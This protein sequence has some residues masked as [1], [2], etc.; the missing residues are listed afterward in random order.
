MRH[1]HGVRHS[2]TFGAVCH[3]LKDTRLARASLTSLRSVVE[4]DTV[5]RAR[6]RRLE[7]SRGGFILLGIE[8]AP[9]LI[10]ACVARS[11]ALARDA[12]KRSKRAF[13]Q[14]RSA[15]AREGAL[16]PKLKSAERVAGG[17]GGSVRVGPALNATPSVRTSRSVDSRSGESGRWQQSFRGL[18]D[19]FSTRR[20]KARSRS[21]PSIATRAQRPAEREERRASVSH[22][23]DPNNSLRLSATGS[24]QQQHQRPSQS[25]PPHAS[26]R[27][28]FSFESTTA[29]DAGGALDD[30]ERFIVGSMSYGVGTEL[31]FEM[32]SPLPG[33]AGAGTESKRSTSSGKYGSS[34]RANG[35]ALAIPN[36]HTFSGPSSNS[37]VNL[38]TNNVPAS[39][40]MAS[41]ETGRGPS[42]G[43]GSGPSQTTLHVPLTNGRA[44][45]PHVHT[46]HIQ[47]SPQQQHS[48]SIHYVPQ[49]DRTFEPDS[50]VDPLVTETYYGQWK[51]DKRCGFGICVRSDGL[52]YEGEL[53]NNMR[54]GTPV[55]PRPL[56]PPA[57]SP[58]EPRLDRVLKEVSG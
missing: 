30:I 56:P 51:A 53:W 47:Y 32:D 1:G 34:G 41:I 43:P 3:F 38:G 18:V 45:G 52:R 33:A 35:P 2:S 50:Y 11:K 6:E 24:L 37:N 17:R 10:E 7:D 22:S 9:E 25:R 40:S 12:A 28:V 26:V 42:P 39:H 55:P 31:P 13:S 49:L 36:S 27:T 8:P 44:G 23:P 14:Q 20:E 58:I 16:K 5:V 54:H 19:F 29:S 46:N 21:T 48:S 57:P 15:S 4:Q